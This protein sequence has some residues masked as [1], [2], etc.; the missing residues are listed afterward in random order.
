M[1]IGFIGNTNNYPFMLALALKR[2]GNEI[3]FVI[4]SSEKLHRPEYYAIKEELAEI[5]FF[6]YPDV[7]EKF[8]NFIFWN[9]KFKAIANDL[10][11]CDVL[12]VNG[13]WPVFAKKLKKP[14]IVLLT[15]TD[16]EFYGDPL[17]VFKNQ[18]KRDE[19]SLLKKI[20]STLVASYISWKQIQSIGHSLAFNYFPPGIVP[21]GDRLLKHLDT[22]S[23][24]LS[25]M[26][27][28]VSRIKLVPP[29]MNEVP[30]VLLA[31]RHSWVLPMKPGTSALDYKGN[32][33]FIRGVSEFINTFGKPLNVILV[34]KGPDVKASEKLIDDLKISKYITWLDEMT[35]AELLEEYHKADV[36]VDQLSDGTIGMVG[37]QAMAIGRPLIA[38]G[39][40]EIWQK[41]LG[42]H[43]PVCQASRPED[44]AKQLH[45]LYE[46]K[47]REHIGFESR[48]YVESYFSSDSAAR[49]CMDVLK[50]A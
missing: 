14:Y 8:Y 24:R 6:D 16:L 12:I 22:S 23:I 15:G 3:Y 21:N 49:I 47:N 45:F 34:R 43:A 35:Q 41:V 4:D 10:S 42:K 27:T 29:P 18:W 30:R 38:N 7:I 48:K 46:R 31:A 26:M 1:K 50:N 13:L 5:K 2:L 20:V 37:L 9:K 33:I 39:R 19:N 17:L 40:P 44:V 25:F 28:D 36:I 11:S 32:D